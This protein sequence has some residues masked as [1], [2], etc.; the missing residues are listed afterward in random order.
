MAGVL[1][2]GVIDVRQGDRWSSY[3]RVSLDASGDVTHVFV[4][5]V[6]FQSLWPADSQAKEPVYEQLYKWFPG[7]IFDRVL[8]VGA[9]TGTD[10]A[11]ALRNGVGHVEAIEIDPL[12]LELGADRHPNRPYDDARV[13]QIVNDGRAYLRTTDQTYD[14]IVF[15]QTDSLTLVGTTA[16]LRLESF[17]FTQQ[18]FESARD[19]L[20]PGGTFVMYNWYREPWLVQRYESM[21][22]RA[23]GSPPIVRSYPRYGVNMAILANGPAIVALHGAAPPGDQIDPIDLSAAPVPATDDWPF[24]Y[25]RTPS[26]PLRYLAALATML[27]FA[28]VAI[29]LCVKATR[30]T[31]RGFSPHFFVLGTAFLLLET[32]SLVTFGLLFGTTWVVNALVFFAILA[33]VLAAIGLNARFRFRDPRP[34]Y[35]ALLISLVVGYVL[36]PSSLLFEPAWLRYAVAAVLTFSPVFFANLVFTR[37]FADTLTADMAFASNLLGAMFGGILEWSALVIG[38]QGLLPVVAVCYLTAYLLASRWRVLAD[39][40]LMLQ[41]PT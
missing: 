15:A 34:L 28:M 27:L 19:H 23:F 25:L 18:A 4:N 11:V 33:S 24:P 13:R 16:N 39:R 22:S 31:V 6:P 3:Y 17:L 20:A 26:V 10:T 21:L 37:S 29:G 9:G 38:Y 32:R 41:R 14:L 5:G 36:A 1:F 2:L 35:G 8:I 30:G 40:Q 12:M 7:K